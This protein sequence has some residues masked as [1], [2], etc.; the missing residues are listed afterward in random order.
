VIGA[1]VRIYAYIYH[2]ALAIVLLAMGAVAAGAH[3][4]LKLD[5]LP[6]HGSTLIQWLLGL[7]IGG[8]L[9]IF[10]AAAGRLR[11]L[12]LLYALGVFGLMFRG[13]FLSSYSFHG[14]DDFRFATLLTA[15]ALL[16][17]AG[18]WPRANRKKSRKRR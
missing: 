18:A 3:T 5:M 8:L 13:Y 10:L 17:I 16:A 15:G 6:W 9:A 2:A 14:K 11:F 12:F 4:E 1:L 7:A